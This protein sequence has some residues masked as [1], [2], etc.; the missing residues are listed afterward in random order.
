MLAALVLGASSVS[1]A[2]ADD[3]AQAAAQSACQFE[4]RGRTLALLADCT[5]RTTIVIP[6]GVT[7][8][9]RHHRITAR[10]PER[11]VFRGAVLTNGGREAHV[12]D[13]I[14]RAAELAPVCDD[15]EQL[16]AIAFHDASGSVVDSEV[17][18]IY[19][20]GDGCGDGLGI[21]IRADYGAA[22]REVWIAGTRVTQF[23]RAGVSVEGHAVIDVQLSRLEHAHGRRATEVVRIAQGASGSLRF[24]WLGDLRGDLASAGVRVLATAGPV[25]LSH[26]HIAEADVGVAIAGAGGVRVEHNTLRALAEAG[27]F[28]DG[29]QRPTT[30]NVIGPN[31]CL[32]VP[33]AA[34]L[35]GAGTREN[36][37]QLAPHTPLR[38]QAPRGA[39][40]V[41]A[42]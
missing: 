21:A 29:R 39:N 13:L 28:L 26:N 36:E 8:D 1:G 22:P 23:G 18:A 20:R 17:E 2:F 42:R 19:R 24:N 10:D 30:D 32:D 25:E 12:R 41:R 40:H 4:Q 14:V 27:V 37:L 6:D 15:R 31:R 35:L 34:W 9:G 33:W 7:L 38:D 16:A 5:T 3:A 11:G